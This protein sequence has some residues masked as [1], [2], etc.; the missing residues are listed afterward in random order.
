MSAQIKKIRPEKQS[1]VEEIRTRISGDAF[2]FFADYT[3]MNSGQTTELRRR[4]RGTKARVQVV[5]NRL[6]KKAAGDQRAATHKAA[7]QGPTAL[8]TGQGDVVETA[9][10]LAVFGKEFQ[11]PVI[12]GGE[13]DG[14]ALTPGDIKALASLPARPILLGQ[15]LGTLVAPMSG[16]VQVLNQ[17]LASV[18]YVLKAVA[19]KK[20]AAQG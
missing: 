6:F 9:K 4:L 18:V 7:L 11:K 3:G 16:F 13:M 15:F 17:K 20:A 2:L 1:V 19:D 14:R 8:I 5:P 10:V 12:K